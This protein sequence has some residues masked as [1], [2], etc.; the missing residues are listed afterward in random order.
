MIENWKRMGSER[1]GEYR[2]FHVRRDRAVSP[3]SGRE[4]SFYV[5]ECSDWVNIIPVTPDG[6]LVFVRQYR[7]GTRET[8]LEVPGGTG[9]LA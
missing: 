7:H 6:K 4:Y 3:R 2:V 8:T 9:H 5:L 1:L